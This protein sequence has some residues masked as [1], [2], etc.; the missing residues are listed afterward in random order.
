MNSYSSLSYEF[1]CYLIFVQNMN[2]LLYLSYE[3]ILFIL[4]GDYYAIIRNWRFNFLYCHCSGDCLKSMNSY[5]RDK[6][7]FIFWTN[8]REHM[9][10]YERDEYEFIFL[11]NDIN[12]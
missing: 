1:I 3:F 9:N 2:S 10:S 12:S 11:K 5:D 8:I 6:Y 7:E 4:D